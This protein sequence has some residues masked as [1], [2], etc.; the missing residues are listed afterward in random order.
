VAQ[1]LDVLV[2]QQLGEFVAAL[3]RQDGCN[4]VEFL[5]AAIDRGFL[6]GRRQSRLRNGDSNGRAAVR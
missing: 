5:G 2:G 3:K 6:V 1:R 4:G